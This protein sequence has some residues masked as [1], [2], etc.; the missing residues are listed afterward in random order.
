MR[1]NGKAL[2]QLDKKLLLEARDKAIELQLDK[3]FIELLEKEIRYREIEEDNIQGV[4]IGNEWTF[5]SMLI[6]R[7]I[8]FIQGIKRAMLWTFGGIALLFI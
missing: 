4:K 5:I 2:D 7:L 1:P 8:N 3:D 6:K